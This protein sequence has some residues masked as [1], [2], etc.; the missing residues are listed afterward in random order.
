MCFA[1]SLRSDS[2]LLTSEAFDASCRYGEQTGECVLLELY[3]TLPLGEGD[4]ECFG[5]NKFSVVFLWKLEMVGNGR[6]RGGIPE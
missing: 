2:Q 1:E 4:G 3:D 6:G 5:W